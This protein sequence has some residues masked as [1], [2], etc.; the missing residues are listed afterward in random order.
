MKRSWFS[1]LI[2]CLLALAVAAQE[3]PTQPTASMLPDISIIGNAIGTLT[4]GESADIDDHLQLQEVEVVF[5]AGIYPG[6]RGDVVIALHDPDF[7]AEVEEGYVTI[8]Q[9]TSSAPVGG[10]IGILRIP[11]GKVNPVHPHQLPY[12]DLPLVTRNLLGEEFIGNGFEVSGLLTPGDAFLQAQVGRW[13]AREQHH[14]EEGEEHEHGGAAFHDRFTTARLWTGLP[15]STKSEVE[16]GVSGGWGQ[17]YHEELDNAGNLVDIHRPD[18]TLYGADVTWRKWLP[19][20]RRL[21]LQAEAVRREQKGDE[22]TKQFGF[23]AL[24]TFQPSKFVELGARYDWTQVPV[25]EGD[26]A[27][28][29]SGV[30]LFATRYLNE[31]TFLRGQVTRGQNH[32][33]ETEHTVT[34][35]LVFG[36]G[37]H[38][39]V[40]Q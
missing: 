12:A 24:G 32:K 33:G 29:L 7:S 15:I 23:V 4:N 14:E 18:I 11:F 8:E 31:T 1:F 30:S 21:L 6:I 37:P 19:R 38:A 16:I 39:H 26:P 34:L 17:G 3:T 27:A 20:E 35:Q 2:L 22:K 10:R 28:H 25:E 36:F 9:F 13:K 40:L 5:G